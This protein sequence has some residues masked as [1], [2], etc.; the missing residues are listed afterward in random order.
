MTQG[1]CLER[2]VAKVES[3]L[4][5]AA[6]IPILGSLPALGKIILGII[7]T[8]GGLLG[9]LFSSALI[10][11]KVGR[12][13]FCRSGSHFANGIANILAGIF[14]AVPIAGSVIN[15]GRGIR[16][17]EGFLGRPK[18][19]TGQEHCY[20]IGYRILEEHPA[21]ANDVPLATLIA[22]GKDPNSYTRTS[23]LLSI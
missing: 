11:T 2:A 21:D 19:F 13:V 12:E 22:R 7:Q 17:E 9:M 20:L 1:I 10:C 14:E 15:C 3:T 8:I 18:L 6:I 23:P 16:R 4:S 5:H